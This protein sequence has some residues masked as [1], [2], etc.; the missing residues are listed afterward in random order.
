MPEP[1]SYGDPQPEDPAPPPGKWPQRTPPDSDSKPHRPV[2]I[3]IGVDDDDDS[4]DA[5]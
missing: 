3:D 5:D 1:I 4:E 2:H